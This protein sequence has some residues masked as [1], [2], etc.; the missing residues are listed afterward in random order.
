[1]VGDRYK[2]ASPSSI[3]YS[4]VVSRERI[5]IAFLLASLDDL[6]ICAYDIG[7]A[8]LDAKCRKKLCTEVGTEFG[9]KKGMLM[10][11]ERALY[12]LKSSGASWRGK[13]AETLVSLVY[14]PYKADADVWMKRN[15]KPNVDPY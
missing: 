3:T 4:S 15:L 14:K 11:I 1:M 10:I 5:R 6:D 2:T 7:N 13:L 9:T 12:G 8:Y